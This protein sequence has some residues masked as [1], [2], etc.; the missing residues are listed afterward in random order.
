MP[1]KKTGREKR[2]E[3]KPKVELP[4]DVPRDLYERF[5]RDVKRRAFKVMTPYTVATHYD[6]KISLAKKILRIAAQNNIVKLY[7]SGR[8]PIYIAG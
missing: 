6:I 8:T 1:R 7:S 2:A 4:L 3:E 5:V